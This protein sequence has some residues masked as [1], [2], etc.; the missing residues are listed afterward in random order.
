MTRVERILPVLLGGPHA[1]TRIPADSRSVVLMP[2][3]ESDH[4]HPPAV[5]Y[6]RRS[7]PVQDVVLHAWSWRP[8]SEA[9][10]QALMWTHLL[11]SAGA[12]IP[13]GWTPTTPAPAPTDA[14]F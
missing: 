7:Y 10:A 5:E 12:L 3:P 1:G 9:E 6:V 11:D 8:M 13:G 14:P 4:G 2:A